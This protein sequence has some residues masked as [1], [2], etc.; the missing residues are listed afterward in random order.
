MQFCNQS[1]SATFESDFNDEVPVE[2][3]RLN[4][5][6]NRISLNEEDESVINNNDFDDSD[7]SN[8]DGKLSDEL[9]AWVNTFGVHHRAIDQLLKIL[10]PYHSDLPLTAKTLLGTKKSGKVI[11]K[12]IASGE[13]I[14]VGIKEGLRSCYASSTTAC[15]TI[16]YQANID[17]IPLFKS[18][19]I[20]LWPVLGKLIDSSL[21]FIIGVFC[22]MSKPSNVNEYLEEFIQEV[23]CLETEGFTVNGKHCYAKL[24]C[25][26]CDAPARALV[27]CVK[28]HTGYSSCERCVQKGE[29]VGNR[30][31]YLETS[32]DLRTD[33][34]FKA[35]SYSNHQLNESPLCALSLDLVNGVVLD[36]MHLICLGVVRR[37]VMYW[38][39]GPVK[40]KLSHSLLLELSAKLEVVKNYIPDEFVRK[41][42][43]SLNL[44]DG[45]LQNLGCSCSIQAPLY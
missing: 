31:V 11:V 22:G 26:V 20:Q 24:D 44:S 42:R 40:V 10:H 45:R 27:K 13:Y 7:D 28:S 17:G 35:M 30:I 14:Y 32:S 39:K 34:N 1:E 5:M 21:I 33:E 29:Y 2:Y 18:S 37:L 25:L 16:K 3:V 38:F 36:Y 8:I 9:V 23:I 12:N 43:H 4:N 41:P 19:G 6:I 15:D